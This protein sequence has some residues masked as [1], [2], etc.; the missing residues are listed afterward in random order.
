MCQPVN[1]KSTRGGCFQ[2]N[3]NSFID[4]VFF[5]GPYQHAAYNEM[6][7][8]K[9]DRLFNNEANCDINTFYHEKPSIPQYAKSHQAP[10]HDE[11]YLQDDECP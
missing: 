9:T 1:Q 5:H 6:S 11:Y 3:E 4:K 8:D 7:H 2:L 10:L